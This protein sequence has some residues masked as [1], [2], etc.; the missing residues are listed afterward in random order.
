MS[1]RTFTTSTKR[2]KSNNNIEINKA[3]LWCDVGEKWTVGQYDAGVVIT[4]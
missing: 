1:P 2:R 3:V 4:L